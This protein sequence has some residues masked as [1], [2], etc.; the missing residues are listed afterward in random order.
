MLGSHF[1]ACAC[2][3]VAPSRHIPPELLSP[4]CSSSAA[5]S[6]FSHWGVERPWRWAPA[7][8]LLRAC[9]WLALCGAGERPCSRPRCLPS[10]SFVSSFVRG[11][12]IF[13][14]FLRSARTGRSVVLFSIVAVFL[15]K[16]TPLRQSSVPKKSQSPRLCLALSAG[17]DYLSRQW[18]GRCEIFVLGEGTKIKRGMFGMRP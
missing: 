7:F 6:A 13:A 4:P 1:C 8:L 15:Q 17:G 5:V 18:Y 12:N 14:P 11:L 3:Y 16:I 2:L 9:L 10:G